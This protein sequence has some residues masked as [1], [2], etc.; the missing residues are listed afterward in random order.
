[1][2]KI[3]KSVHW[4]EE[5]QQSSALTS[6][7]V[8]EKQLPSLTF[9]YEANQ[10]RDMLKGHPLFKDYGDKN[11]EN[12]IMKVSTPDGEV[13]VYMKTHSEANNWLVF[14]HE[15]L[16]DEIYEWII[17]THFPEE[18]TKPPEDSEIYDA[19]SALTEEEDLTLLENICQRGFDINDKRLLDHIDFEHPSAGMLRGMDALGFDIN[20]PDDI[21]GEPYWFNWAMEVE[22]S[23]AVKEL[24]E[25]PGLDINAENE[26][27]ETILHRLDACTGSGDVDEEQDLL[28]RELAE[29]FVEKG[30][31]I[32]RTNNKGENALFR[33]YDYPLT[34][35]YL[36]EQGMDIN[37]KN[38]K[39]LT[40]FIHLC[41]YLNRR[42]E[43][44]TI[45]ET[46]IKLGTDIQGEYTG[47]DSSRHGWTPLHFAVKGGQVQVVKELLKQGADALHKTAHNETPLSI[48]LE[49]AKSEM[50]DLIRPYY[51]DV[52]EDHEII[53]K[54]VFYF[55]ANQ[56]WQ[57]AVTWGEKAL[58]LDIKDED[59]WNY[60]SGAYLKN[61]QIERA[62]DLSLEAV[63]EFGV[64]N[65]LMDTVV[66]NYLITGQ[67]E[68]AVKFWENNRN[69][70]IP[71]KDP[72][73]NILAHILVAYDQTVRHQEGI[74]Q[75]K[76]HFEKAD[77]TRIS[78]NGLLH[79]NMA[80]IYAKTEDVENSVR[81][82]IGAKQKGYTLKDFECDDFDA[83]RDHGFFTLFLTYIEDYLLYYYFSKE[84]K[85]I[86]LYTRMDREF[87][88]YIFDGKKYTR[89]IEETD[90]AF[91]ML[92]EFYQVREKAKGEGYIETEPDFKTPWIPFFDDLFKRIAKDTT[93]PLGELR[94]EWDFVHDDDPELNPM[95]RPYYA[96]S[97]NGYEIDHLD[98]ILYIP[99]A[100]IHNALVSEAVALKSF[101]KLNK[102]ET[103]KIIQSEHDSGDEFTFIWEK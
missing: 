4:E 101:K 51:T 102:K 78:K 43:G 15:E 8:P 54:M 63:E 73:A 99:K 93:E 57:D 28:G 92:K 2:E 18:R 64:S 62:I 9:E 87:G 58:S 74:D 45:A 27:G 61:N 96:Y 26:E 13:T 37:R 46:W 23:E 11:W 72:A 47:S 24:C 90:S 33:L 69:T 82:A 35:E 53:K 12:I 79:F 66:Y 19:L 44:D 77:G 39:G 41:R 25:I 100:D 10:C 29:I 52:S 81:M 70:F 55:V 32:Q 7:P 21:M 14:P 86:V 80:C 6:G 98:Y 20:A 40:P 84:N 34:V 50:V 65:S 17:D 94:V 75:V 60:L 48:A 49:T 97:D 5:K 1:M 103:V 56:Q 38:D 89:E 42:D 36:V 95:E 85:N 67:P 71:D 83:V 91:D 22:E 76:P 88:K 31:D 3:Y 16:R 68:E 59:T 30:A